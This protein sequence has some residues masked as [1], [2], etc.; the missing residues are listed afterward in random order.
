M[1]PS[2]EMQ[3]LLRERDELS[4]RLNDALGRLAA[5]DAGAYSLASPGGRPA[6]ADSVWSRMAW[7][8][9]CR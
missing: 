5:A 6:T 1:T 7:S 8:A 4:R 9:P 3:T 2:P